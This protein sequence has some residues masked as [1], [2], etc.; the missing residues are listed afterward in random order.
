MDN[1][2]SCEICGNQTSFEKFS[3]SLPH[4]GEK[5]NVCDTWVCVECVNWE[6]M[7][8]I[9]VEIPICIECASKEC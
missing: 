3:A 5:C 8:K 6:F 2:I 1:I 4:E 9:V 7:S